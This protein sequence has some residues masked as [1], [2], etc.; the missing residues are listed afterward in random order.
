MKIR[1]RI[2]RP[3]AFIILV[4]LLAVLAILGGCI[5]GEQVQRKA[6]LETEGTQTIQQ[7]GRR[8]DTDKQP[9]TGVD[10][11]KEGKRSLQG[12]G[13]GSHE[14]IQPTTENQYAE[15]R[16]IN[17]VKTKSGPALLSSRGGS[18]GAAYDSNSLF[19]T[20]GEEY[21]ITAYTAGPESTGKHP[22]DSGYGIT[23]S[24]T[25][26]QE[27]HTI[28]ADLSVLPL[29]TKILIEGIDA[30]FVVE[31]KGGA[32]KGKHID[33]YMSQLS[34]AMEWGVQYRKIIILEMGVV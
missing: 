25:K 11:L 4:A 32:V 29:G 21:T 15:Y 22:G 24:G 12:K 7:E 17:G 16:N 10:R 28:A 33:L 3:R 26:V 34:D 8:N 9:G 6:T 30:V 18:G 19:D 20:I 31:D 5:D 14:L 27:N 1:R 13:T 2:I 23:C